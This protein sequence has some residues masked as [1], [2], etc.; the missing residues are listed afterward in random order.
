M[1]EK[2]AISKPV[3]IKDIP[4]VVLLEVVFI[5]RLFILEDSIMFRK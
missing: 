1:S 4:F 2:C 3:N 5:Q